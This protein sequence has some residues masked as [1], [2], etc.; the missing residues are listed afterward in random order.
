MQSFVD[1]VVVITGAGAGMGRA[2]ALEFGKL[3]AKLALNDFDAQALQA[4][5]ALLQQQGHMPQRVL[6]QSFDVGSREDMQAFAQSVHSTLGPA[7]VV[8]NNAGISGKGS[9][10]YTLSL[11]EIERA[12]HV[13][14]YGVVH[15]T[16]AFLPQL[17]QQPQAVLVNVCSVLGL[18]GMPGN[19]DYCASKFAV[20]GY[21]EALMVELAGTPI[22]V[23]LLH[24]GGVRTSIADGT[25]KGR[26]LAEKYFKTEPQAVAKALVKGIRSK[27]ARIV[28]GHQSQQ[29]WWL[30]WALPLRWRNWLLHRV[31]RRW[32]AK[33][34]PNT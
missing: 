4:T 33:S 15:G 20:R 24:P 19:A 27:Q 16:Q 6:A 3:G 21:T 32:A 26:K 18:V 7:A 10:V 34:S 30:S 25:E 29:L 1:Q 2:Y 31:T 14:F 13:N 8:I 23:H 22:S 28:Y 9:R 11:Q 17:M 12:M 5:L